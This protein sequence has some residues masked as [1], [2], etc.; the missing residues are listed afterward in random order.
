MSTSANL[1]NSVEKK[2]QSLIRWGG[3]IHIP[4]GILLMVS[5]V[6]HPSDVI[7]PEVAQSLFWRLIH[8]GF[9]ISLILGILGLFALLARY[10]QQNGGL[11][12]IVSS[13]MAV[14][15]LFLIG[16]LDYA[17]VFIF[18][19][20]AVEFPAVI[21][22]YGAGETM[23]SVAFAFP[24]A[25][26]FTVVGYFLFSYALYQ[27]KSVSKGSAF[28]TMVGAIVFGLGL[29]GFPPFIVAQI[30]AVAFGLGLIWLGVSLS[31]S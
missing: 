2:L 13:L 20:L 29:S 24:L 27:T 31:R 22:K 3:I 14:I 10:I 5:Y 1:S 4:A 7:T 9:L 21:E 23:P 15:G 28:M 16:G 18:P 25:G 19:T 30:G 12:G 26:M 8:G 17:E 6:L 11:L